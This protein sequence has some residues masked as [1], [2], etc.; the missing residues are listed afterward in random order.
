MNSIKL[1]WV[2][3]RRSNVRLHAIL[4]SNKEA[5][6]IMA[7]EPWFDTVS[8]TRSDSNPEGVEVLGTVANPLWETFL[9]SFQPGE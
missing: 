5:D 7:Q 9:P 8:T 4:N 1:L 2:N 3:A 6:L